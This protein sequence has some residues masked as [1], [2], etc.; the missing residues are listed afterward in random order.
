MPDLVSDLKIGAKIGNG[1]FGEVFEGTDPAH[2]DVAVK[3]LS[4]KAQDDDAAWKRYKD[5]ALS[6]AKNLSKAAHPN[7]VKVHHVVE[8]DDGESVF[9]CMEYCAGG[10][11]EAKFD[12]GPMNLADVKKA[13]TEVLLGLSALHARQMIHRDIKPGNIL[14]DANGAAKLSDFGLVTDDLV[15]GYAS[16]QGY[17]DHVAF[18][19]WNGNG[20]SVKSDVWA[21]GMTVYRLLHGKAWY[22]AQPIPHFVIRNGS[23]AKSL[24]WLPHVPKGWRR[25]LRKMM[26]DDTTARHQNVAQVLQAIA[27]LPTVPTWETT[28][29]PA[30]VRWTRTKGA[31]RITVE[32]DRHSARKH[33]WKA[34]S[35]PAG[36]GNTRSLG[37]S[38]G[39]VGSGKAI[40]ELESFFAKA[41]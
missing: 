15:Q 14:L 5:N 34:W 12:A 35:E 39:I 8:K 37:G 22:N 19:V 23:F 24:K 17:R 10:S 28:V 32:W 33:E 40:A 36:K 20:T 13:T 18:E 25:L 11:L 30:Q 7:V 3:V 29:T 41:S 1:H 4:R 31:R 9:I 2:G 26:N 38:N 21:L 6:E 27:S 16:Q